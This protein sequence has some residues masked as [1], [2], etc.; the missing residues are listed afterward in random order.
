M[1]TVLDLNSPFCSLTRVATVLL[2]VEYASLA[3]LHTSRL[4]YFSGKVPNANKCF[5]LWNLLFVAVRLASV[6]ISV[7]V[8]WYGL[9]SHETPFVNL[10]TGNFNTHVIRWVLSMSSFVR[11]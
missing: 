1:V 5:R 9:R 2:A 6:V 3:V 10:E 11:L 7:L 4:F 8:L